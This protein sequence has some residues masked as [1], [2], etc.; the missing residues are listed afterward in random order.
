[1]DFVSNEVFQVVPTFCFKEKKYFN[2]K[3]S[4]L[5]VRRNSLP[6]KKHLFFAVDDGIERG[7]E[8][9]D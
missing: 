5:R 4:I 3:K 2:R 7:K 6:A 1:V 8:K 9:Q